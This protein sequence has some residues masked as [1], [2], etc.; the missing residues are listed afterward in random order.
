MDPLSSDKDPSTLPPKPLYRGQITLNHVME[1]SDPERYFTAVTEWADSAW[2][3]WRM[4]W[5]Q[6][7][8]WV[9]EACLQQE[10][11]Y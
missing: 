1:I 8:K 3:A 6:A 4:H 11:K 7:R 2:N 9:E 10:K 5:P